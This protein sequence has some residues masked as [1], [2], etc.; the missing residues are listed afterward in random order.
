[1]IVRRG[2]IIAIAVALTGCEAPPLAKVGETF[3]AQAADTRD[4]TNGESAAVLELSAIDPASPPPN[5]EIHIAAGKRDKWR[6][7]RNMVSELGSSGKKVRLLSAQ[8]RRVGEFVLYEEVANRPIEVV[9]RTNGQACIRLPGVK[10]AKCVQ[11]ADAKHIDRAHLRQLVREAIRVSKIRDVLVYV[12]GDMEWADV[13][14]AVDA[15]RTCCKQTMRPK[16]K[17]VDLETRQQNDGL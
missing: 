14:R 1:M 12:P 16:V 15:A 5:P 11:R 9:A 4:I 13:V 6:D 8:R 2:V 7:I 3:L 17:L 10:E